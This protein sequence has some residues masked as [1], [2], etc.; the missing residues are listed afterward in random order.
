MGDSTYRYVSTVSLS[1]MPEGRLPSWLLCS[2]LHVLFDPCMAHSVSL[3]TVRGAAKETAVTALTVISAT[4]VSRRCLQREWLAGCRAP[5][6][7][8]GMRAKHN[9][10]GHRG[11]WREEMLQYS[12]SRQRRQRV[13]DACRETAELVVL[14]QTV[15]CVHVN[16]TSC[17][18]DGPVMV[19]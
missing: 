12:Q 16:N 13:E 7:H 10:P 9:E 3:T 4:R 1:K 6:C 14:Q 2:P 11:P 18:P 15:M 17:E 8:Y 5:S 19:D